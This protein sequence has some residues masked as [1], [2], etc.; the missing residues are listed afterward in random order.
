MDTYTPAQGLGYYSP[1][2][3]EAWAAAGWRFDTWRFE[4]TITIILIL[5]MLL[6]T[7]HTIIYKQNLV[8]QHATRYDN[9][10]I[11]LRRLALRGLLRL[12]RLGL[13]NII[14]CCCFHLF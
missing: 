13:T 9:D 3:G 14:L 2:P 6:L 5:L 12:G 8:I 7:A 11:Q 1:L 10:I 4:H